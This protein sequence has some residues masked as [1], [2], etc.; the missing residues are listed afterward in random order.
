ML[1]LLLFGRRIVFGALRAT[2]AAGRQQRRCTSVE[3]AVGAE[4]KPDGC[5]PLRA[6]MMTSG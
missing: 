1:L 6:V 4:C 5:R 3:P 2:A